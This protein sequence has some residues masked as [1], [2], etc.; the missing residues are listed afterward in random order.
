MDRFLWIL[1]VE[2]ACLFAVL[3]E[4]FGLNLGLSFLLVVGLIACFCK[5]PKK[6]V[7]NWDEE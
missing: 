2:T 7:V 4:H 5:S 1:G 3:V 6:K